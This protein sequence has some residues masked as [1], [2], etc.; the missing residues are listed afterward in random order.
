MDSKK[1]SMIRDIVRLKQVVK[2]WRKQAA[3]SNVDNNNKHETISTPRGCLAVCVGK[4]EKRFVI[5][6]HYLRRRLF[7]MLLRDAEEEFGFQNEG[8]LRM[9]CTV[10]V[11][12]KVLQLLE[13][14]KETMIDSVKCKNWLENELSHDQQ[15]CC[16]QMCR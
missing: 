2:K 1:C 7:V 16:S 11:F 3:S 8:V 4:E 13:H 6:M 15:Y 9:P 10:L 12:E 5:P 14:E